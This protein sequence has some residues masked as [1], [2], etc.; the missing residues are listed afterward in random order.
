MRYIGDLVD[1]KPEFDDIHIIWIKREEW[2]IGNKHVSNPAMWIEYR[3]S[4]YF[5]ICESYHFH[6]LE[7]FS[8]WDNF[9]QWAPGYLEFLFM[10]SLKPTFYKLD[11]LGV[12]KS[13]LGEWCDFELDFI[14]EWW[15]NKQ[16]DIIL[17]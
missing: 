15:R 6:F 1:I 4:I 9:D 16:I 3:D 2:T 7:D 17:L 14:K 8:D 5:G 13:D 12:M 11:Y 10:M